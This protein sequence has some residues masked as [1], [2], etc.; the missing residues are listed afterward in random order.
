MEK[1]LLDDIPITLEGKID[2]ETIQAGMIKTWKKKL[3]EVSQDEP[4]S[5]PNVEVSKPAN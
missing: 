1:N 3:E 5:T 2:V 4:V